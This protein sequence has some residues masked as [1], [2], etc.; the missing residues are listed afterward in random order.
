MPFGVTGVI[1][2]LWVLIKILTVQEI[3]AN[4]YHHSKMN[5]SKFD[6]HLVDGYRTGSN[7]KT[8]RPLSTIVGGLYTFLV[9][10][11][12]ERRHL[13]GDRTCQAAGVIIRAFVEDQKHHESRI[14]ARPLILGWG[15][16]GP[17]TKQA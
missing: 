15:L 4:S 3:T 10:K 14:K 7:C 5:L 8:Q 16:C 9:K 13:T 11:Q 6:R 1:D 17:V 12:S 2:L